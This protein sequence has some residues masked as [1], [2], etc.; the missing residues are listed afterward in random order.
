MVPV[1]FICAADEM[2]PNAA[3]L[4]ALQERGAEIIPVE[5][6]A[7]GLPAIREAL[8]QL[9][10][11]GITR[12]LVEGGAGL[13]TALLRARLVDRLAWFYAPVIVGGDGL[14]AI[15]E[16]ERT[17]IAE[18]IRFARTDSRTLAEDTLQSYILLSEGEACSPASSPTS[19]GSSRSPKTLPT[20][21]D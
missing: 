11:R 4:H 17:T 19:A 16:L 8:D 12:L 10:R 1:W 21:G 3:A 2:E 20:A 14:A 5:I 18:A 15:G 9:A 7:H 13:A 6:D